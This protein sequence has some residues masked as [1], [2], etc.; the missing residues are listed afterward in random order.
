M[1]FV[2]RAPQA[3]ETRFREGTRNSKG[4]GG[5]SSAETVGG[6]RRVCT[7]SACFVCEKPPDGFFRES[8][9]AGRKQ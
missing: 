9:A 2:L 6:I 4:V 8:S 7:L 1:R 3:T 5:G